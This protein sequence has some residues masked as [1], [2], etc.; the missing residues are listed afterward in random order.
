VREAGGPRLE[1]RH[2][3]FVRGLGVADLHAHAPRHQGR[4][5][6]HRAVDLRR[7]REHADRRDFVQ[8]QDFLNRRRTHAVR[9]RAELARTDV[10]AFQVHAE[11]ARRTRRAL[12]A[13]RRNRAQGVFQLGQRR[14]HRG[15]Q[16]RR[17]AVAG[18]HPCQ[19]LDGIAAFHG[20][21]AAA[22]VHVQVDE[23]GQHDRMGAR[24]HGR[25]IHRH[26]LDRRHAAIGKAHAPAHEAIGREQM[27][28]EIGGIVHARSMNRPAMPARRLAARCA[29]APRR[30]T[31]GSSPRTPR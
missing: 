13:Q 22:A 30:R 7:Q 4:D 14:G 24:T 5:H 18:V 11:H 16:Q 6:R 20:V 17:R 10:R 12:A 28:V 27:T 29:A 8:R 2:R 25:F 3:L 9:L 21:G 23:A 31:T 19:A 1:G 15:G 26:A